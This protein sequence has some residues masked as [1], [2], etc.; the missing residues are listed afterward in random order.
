MR[1]TPIPTHLFKHSCP[2][3]NPHTHT[4][5]YCYATH[6]PSEEEVFS[7]CVDPSEDTGPKIAYKIIH[8]L[9]LILSRTLPIFSQ[10]FWS[11]KRCLSLTPFNLV[12]IDVGLSNKATRHGFF[13][14]TWMQFRDSVRT[15]S[16]HPSLLLH[17]LFCKKKERWEN[18][19][20]IFIPHFLVQQ[21]LF[22]MKVWKNSIYIFRYS[23]GSVWNLKCK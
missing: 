13:C 3:T 1:P 20:D 4:E 9:W 7:V 18:C 22:E 15:Y 12:V 6:F 2:H 11:L 10:K 8:C 21:H 16:S 17:I 5:D 14:T 19:S 23:T